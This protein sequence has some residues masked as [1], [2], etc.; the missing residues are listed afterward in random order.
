MLLM[1]VCVE[2]GN[3]AIVME[4]VEGRDL[5]DIISDSSVALSVEQR[6]K[7][8]KDVAVSTYIIAI[9]VM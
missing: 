9:F 1:G 6:L 3:I 7:I 5:G 4:Y 8:A 2:Q